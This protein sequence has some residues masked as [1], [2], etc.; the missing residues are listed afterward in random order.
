MVITS[1]RINA[2]LGKRD[3]IVKTLGSLLGPTRVLPGCLSCNIY[4]DLEN[5]NMLTLI[6]EWESRASLDRHVRSDEFRRILAAIDL[7]SEPPEIRFCSVASTSG[8]E[9][10]E[11][12]RG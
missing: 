10:I 12:I 4:Q 2:P 8:I 3:E 7:A 1:V 9:L 11:E 6:E 5:P